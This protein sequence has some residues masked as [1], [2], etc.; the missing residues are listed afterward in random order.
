MADACPNKF[1]PFMDKTIEILDNIKHFCVDTIRTQ[2]IDCYTKLTTGIIKSHYGGQIPAY[3]QGLP[4][5]ERY[6]S[7]IEDFFNDQLLPLLF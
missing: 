5:H 6:P 7:N 2:V 3:K 4:C 1:A